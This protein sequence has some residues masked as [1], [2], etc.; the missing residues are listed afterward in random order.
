M[1]RQV[2]PIAGAII[3]G[4]I[5]GPTGAQIGYAA[6]SIIGNAVDPLEVTGNKVG[7]NPLQTASEGGARAIVFGRGCIRATCILDRGNRRVVKQREQAGKG[8]G[9]VTINERVFWTFAIGLG[10]A[11]VGGHI[12][13]I[14]EGE[15]LVYDVTPTSTMIEES[16]AF[17]EKFRFYDGNEE[18]LPDPDLEAIHGIDNTPYYRGTAYVVFPNFDL[19][20][21]REAI[22]VYRWEVVTAGTTTS[23]AFAM[24]I[25][26]DGVGTYTTSSADGTAFT[27]PRV[28]GGQWLKA[29]TGDRFFG[30]SGAQSWYSDDYGTT[31]VLVANP[32]PASAGFQI[33]DY[34]NGILLVPGGQ[35]NAAVWRST[36][37]AESFTQ[38]QAGDF[39]SMMVSMTDSIAVSVNPLD[40]NCWKSS[41][42]GITWVM[43]G[44]HGVGIA[45]SHA[46]S[47]TPF[48][49][50][51]AGGKTGKPFVTWTDNGED[52]DSSIFSDSDGSRVTAMHTIATAIDDFTWVACTN[53]GEVYVC[54]DESVTWFK[55]PDIDFFAND[56]S[57]N[58]RLWLFAGAT[59]AGD[60][61]VMTSEDLANFNFADTPYTNS[62]LQVDA[63]P[64]MTPTV[65]PGKIL[66]SDI[67]SELH[68]R[69]GH[70]ASQYDVSELTDLVTGVVF[71]QSV[72]YAEAI[73]QCI[74]P[75]FADPAD[76][77]KE[78]HYIKRG[79]PVVRTLDFDDLIDEPET[80]MRENAIEYPRKLHLFFQSPI[81][82]YAATKATS[83]RSSPDV[84]VIGE[85]SIAVPITFAD[86][87]EPAQISSKLHKVYW[88]DAEGEL[89]W[90][91]TDE[92]LDLVPTDCVGL[93]LRGVVRRARVTRIEDD[94]GQRKLIMRVDRQ[95]AYTSNVTGIPLPEPTPPQPSII[96]PAILAVLDIPALIDSADDLHYLAAMSGSS[97]VWSGAVLQRSLDDGS[98]F[99]NVG[100]VSLNAIMGTL[101]SDVAAASPHYTDTTNTVR[102][103]LYTDDELNSITNTQFL[104]EQGAFV[105]SYT[106][107]SGRRWEILQGRDVQDLGDGLFEISHLIRGCLNTEAAAHPS[108]SLFVWLDTSLLKLSAQTAWLEDELQH[109][110]VSNGLSPESA[111]PQV[112]TYTGQSQVEFPVG[113][114][115]GSIDSTGLTVEVIPRHRF[116]TDINPIRSL[117]WTGYRITA[118]SGANS[119][120]IETTSD[121]Y[122]FDISGWSLPVSVTVAQIN[123]LTGDGPTF[124]EQ[125]P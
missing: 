42:N 92:H 10:E 116:G 3:G 94:P 73:N 125:F 59:Y 71:E 82:A 104:S 63:F 24:A 91:V 112:M 1:A 83:A 120:S 84:R 25:G 39:S 27:Q 100:S 74:G 41:D 43:G 33:G 2:L 87:D 19:T 114:I 57:Y 23:L 65:D 36:N 5:G 67:V 28:G 18:Q 96:A 108:G 124:T 31:K 102:V 89:E 38:V 52:F 21:Y 107:S 98:S 12:L 90:Q 81:T 47:S 101:Q 6:G 76:Y 119:Q 58:G 85:A 110:A 68:D 99:S 54:T 9:P 14:W 51:F 115:L 48:H 13:R 106:D 117:N 11:M 97:D 44:V 72:T 122:T 56:V 40:A 22:P 62:V 17:A 37:N 105:L 15:K 118:T 64:Q 26:S 61:V 66:L 29:M 46:S 32:P 45:V 79:K 103:Q 8:G 34:R 53:A 113:A 78:I 4:I 121:T 35:F 49:A 123:R 16:T 20:D 93:S 7:D 60:M 88:T 77:D 95:S 80:S 69:A 109:R 30:L 111:T 86:V 50:F 55:V 70:S 75:Y